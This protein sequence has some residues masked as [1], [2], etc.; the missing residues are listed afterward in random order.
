MRRLFRS[1]LGRLAP[2]LAA[3]CLCAL[4]GLAQ[5]AL[6][7]A[8]RQW[9][10]EDVTYLVTPVERDVFLKLTTDRERDLF[11]AAF[12]NHRVGKPGF[13]GTSFRA[14]HYKRFAHVNRVFGR[15]SPVPGWKTDR[16]RIYIV[17][18][19][20]TEQRSYDARQ[21]LR[22]VEV[23]FYQGREALGLPKGFSLVFFQRDGFG[24]YQM[25]SPVKDGPSTM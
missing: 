16:G 25:Y 22:P 6:P 1:R 17:L 8:Y 4:S 10:E 5:T 14:E 18:G 2:S 15:D 19:P 13:D 20:P 9:L 21:G 23:W 7:Q 24:D 3:V 11:M 12:W